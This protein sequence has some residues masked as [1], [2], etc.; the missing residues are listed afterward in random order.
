[1]DLGRP[2][3][4]EPGIPELFSRLTG[5]ARE[6]AQAEIALVKAKVGDGVTRYRSAAI[7]FA[8]AGT[9]AFCGLI[10]LL[11]G[12]ILSLATLVGPGFATAIV[13]GI[14]LIVAGIFAW[15]GR[16]ALAPVSR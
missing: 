14:V 2:V 13:V 11:F 3:L 6:L 12:L 15:R 7:N 1:M 5:D 4:G 9:L 10:A 16:A 8:I